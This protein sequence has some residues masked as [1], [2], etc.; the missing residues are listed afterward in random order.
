M[1]ITPTMLAGLGYA[2][3]VVV[4]TILSYFAGRSAA[5][6]CLEHFKEELTGSTTAA[7]QAALNSI[8]ASAGPIDERIERSHAT[9]QGALEKAGEAKALTREAVEHA[10]AAEGL[11][12]K[13]AAWAEEASAR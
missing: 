9:A 7:V 8:M 5:R 6:R 1:I 13:S 10:H 3:P 2:G 4:S 11:A 12:E